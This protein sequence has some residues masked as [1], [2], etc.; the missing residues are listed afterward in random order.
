M[1]RV[2]RYQTA[3]GPGMRKPPLAVRISMPLRNGVSVAKKSGGR[4]S[5]GI[6]SS[7]G[8]PLAIAGI[9]FGS[10]RMRS[11]VARTTSAP[12]ASSR[13]DTSWIL[14]PSRTISVSMV[15]GA[16]GT[17][18][19]R[20][21]VRRATRIGTGDGRRLDR[22][23]DQRRG[24]RAVLQLG[25]PRTAGEGA[26]FGGGVFDA[27]DCSYVSS[28]QAR[29]YGD[30]MG[31]STSGLTI[32]VFNIFVKYG[33]AL[34]DLLGPGRSHAPRDPR[35]TCAAAAATVGDLAEP[36]DMSLPAVS[37]H[38]KVLTEAGL[39][40]RHTEA[41]WRRCELRGE[42][43]APPPTGS[44]TTASSGKRASTGSTPS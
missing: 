43:C 17:G 3:A 6:G 31:A 29:F 44:S 23:A 11:A 5:S 39:I 9:S 28:V 30:A 13:S 40:E 37:R 4:Q 38:L 34:P 14:R 26:G 7:T 42:G 8:G 41:Q 21:T 15:S 1:G 33:F 19:I 12:S 20:S 18:R 35:A 24:R 27:V 2:A 25:I 22:P 32:S 36:F 10:M 16:T